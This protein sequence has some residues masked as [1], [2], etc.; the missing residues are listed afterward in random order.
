[1][2]TRLKGFRVW[3]FTCG[4]DASHR[5]P[6][7]PEILQYAVTPNRNHTLILPP[8]E[9]EKPNGKKTTWR[10]IVSLDSIRTDYVCRVLVGGRY[11]EMDEI[12]E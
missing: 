11:W 12:Q 4:R 5:F 2:E 10:I 9:E 8:V 7:I 6:P 3:V 1:M